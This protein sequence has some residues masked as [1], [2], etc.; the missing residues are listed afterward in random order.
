[1]ARSAGAPEQAER[2]QIRQRTAPKK[3]ARLRTMPCIAGRTITSGLILRDAAKAPLVQPLVQDEG[4]VWDTRVE[5]KP[6]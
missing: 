5:I 6:R 3:E 1:M 2:Q 4:P